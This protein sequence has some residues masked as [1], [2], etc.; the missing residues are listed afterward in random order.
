MSKQLH[1]IIFISY[2]ESNADKNWLQLKER[3]PRAKRVHGVAGILE[4]HQEAARRSNTDFFFTIDGDNQILPSF[5]FQNIHPS[6]CQDSLYVWRCRNPVNGLTYGYGAVKLYNKSIIGR[7]T[8][9][10][11]SDLATTAFRHYQIIDEVASETHF[12]CTPKEA[13]RGAFRECAKLTQ[14][15]QNNPR[16]KQTQERL[17]IWCH[18]S[19]DHNNGQWVI[20]GANSGKAFASNINTG[21]SIAKFINN[22]EWLEMK[23]IQE[24]EHGTF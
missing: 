24:N 14:Q 23:F 9:L 22:F 10:K 19:S 1:D 6:L 20:R 5:S 16:D 21:Q 2:L 12:H 8:E 13:W 15:L 7:M 3:F 11:E 17:H 4:A 18:H